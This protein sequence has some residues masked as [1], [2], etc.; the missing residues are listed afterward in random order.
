MRGH[1]IGTPSFP[2]SVGE[3]D[4]EFPSPCYIPRRSGTQLG[5]RP[6]LLVWVR[7]M[8]SFHHLVI[9]PEGRAHLI[10]ELFEKCSHTEQLDVLSRLTLCLKRDFLVALPLELTER[11]LSYLDSTFV[12]GTCM[13]VRSLNFRHAIPRYIFNPEI[14]ISVIKLE[15]SQC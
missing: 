8:E 10:Q 1:T 6:F 14:T 11:I 3:D 4:G 9:S 2:F 13:L 12:L 5:H 15:T 7:M